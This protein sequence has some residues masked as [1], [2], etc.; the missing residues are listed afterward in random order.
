MLSLITPKFKDQLGLYRDDGTAVCKVTQMQIEKTKQE[1]SNVFKSNDLSIPI[2][3]NKKIVNFLYLTL[4]LSGA[5]YK[6]NMKPKNKVLY[7][8]DKVSI[9]QHY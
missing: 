2:E 8:S 4:D 6:P 7:V 5:S 9:P 1:A 3:A